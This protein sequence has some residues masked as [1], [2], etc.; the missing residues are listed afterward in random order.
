MNRS[1]E[2]RILG[3][4]TIG[5]LSLSAA[6]AWARKPVEPRS[7]A[8]API[9]TMISVEEQRWRAIVEPE[10]LKGSSWQLWLPSQAKLRF[11]VIPSLKVKLPAEEKATNPRWPWMERE[12]I[13]SYEA[14]G[15]CTAEPEQD[16]AGGVRYTLEAEAQL[17]ALFVAKSEERRST[18]DRGIAGEQ[19][20]VLLYDEVSLYQDRAALTG[21]KNHPEQA[22]ARCLGEPPAEEAKRLKQLRN[23]YLEYS[24]VMLL[25]YDAHERET[26]KKRIFE[27]ARTRHRLKEDHWRGASDRDRQR[28]LELLQRLDGSG[29][30]RDFRRNKSAEHDNKELRALEAF[31]F[32]DPL[33]PECLRKQASSTLLLVSSEPEDP[34]VKP[35][36]QGYR[37]YTLD[38][39]ALNGRDELLLER[40]PAQAGQW[41]VVIDVEGVTQ[42]LLVP[43]GAQG[44]EGRHVLISDE[45]FLPKSG[46]VPA[47]LKLASYRSKVLS[48]GEDNLLLSSLQGRELIVLASHSPE[49]EEWQRAPAPE[50]LKQHPQPEAPVRFAERDAR[51]LHK[52]L[53]LVGAKGAETPT[54]AQGARSGL[55]S[56]AQSAPRPASGAASSL[57]LC[58]L[59]L[60]AWMRRKRGLSAAKLAT[61]FMVGSIGQLLTAP[62][63]YA[64][65]PSEAQ[66]C[67]ARAMAIWDGA[68]QSA[69][70]WRALCSSTAQALPQEYS[71]AIALPEAP[72]EL[73]NPTEIVKAQAPKKGEAAEMTLRQ[74]TTTPKENWDKAHTKALEAR[75]SV[76]EYSYKRVGYSLFRSAS[77]RTACQHAWADSSTRVAQGL[78][79]LEPLC[80]RGWQVLVLRFK[81]V[82]PKPEPKLKAK[83]KSKQ[84]PLP[85]LHVG[86]IPGA[87]LVWDHTKTLSF[88]PGLELTYVPEGIEASKLVKLFISTP[89]LS[90][91]DLLGRCYKGGEAATAERTTYPA[92]AIGEAFIPS[93]VEAKLWF[94]LSASYAAQTCE[95]DKGIISVGR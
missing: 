1:L 64:Q 10:A 34:A 66:V 32:L 60:V 88:D 58:G 54:Q 70:H 38:V 57:W 87:E 22:R 62:D 81:L 44:L 40:T 67:G 69:E 19:E 17:A 20:P 59:G 61:L 95:R 27:L 86:Y 90:P 53:S 73:V 11:C 82:G 23:Y 36:R 28:A 24:Q 45:L 71:V 4:A 5:V 43:G 31:T 85:E 74:L 72:V 16:E 37:R 80:R 9:T 8:R 56:C 68:L 33:K 15:Y 84:P 47:E 13:S 50:V 65:Q 55:L 89:F 3:A 49:L 92:R 6:S 35:P 93:K 41:L 79:E 51:I 12:E 21:V 18:R 29:A 39:E 52:N 25:H 30:F 91:S 83:K 14:L 46:R 7:E 75:Y 26:S 63:A 42:P 48:H 94:N 77:N 76:V 2:R 78:K